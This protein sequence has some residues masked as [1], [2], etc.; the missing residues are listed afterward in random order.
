[1][2]PLHDDLIAWCREQRR[3]MLR[4]AERLEARTM[5]TREPLGGVGWSDTSEESAAD[6][7]RR[8]A[9]LDALIGSPDAGQPPA[10]EPLR[11]DLGL[12]PLRGKGRFS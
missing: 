10:P 7:R 11:L 2:P 5:Q 9:Q 8:I 3:E 12:P 1:M 6:V 4:R